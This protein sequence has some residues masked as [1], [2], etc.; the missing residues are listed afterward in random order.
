MLDKPVII[1]VEDEDD[2]PND[3]QLRRLALLTIEQMQLESE[4]ER[5]EQVLKD[6]KAAWREVA[7]N[8]LPAAIAEAGV[9]GFTMPDGRKVHTK[10]EVYASIPAKNREAAFQWLRENKLDGVIKNEVTISLGRGEDA[11]AAAACDYLRAMGFAPVQ[12][13]SIHPQT[14]KALIREQLEKGVE[15]PLDVFGAYVVTRAE[16]KTK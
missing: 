15:I 6:L 4:I 14:L 1:E 7:E 11:Q 9:G 2:L 5:Q 8:K 10:Q 12:A 16:V 3:D 13:E